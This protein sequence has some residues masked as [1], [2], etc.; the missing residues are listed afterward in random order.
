[1]D[2]INC[3]EIYEMWKIVHDGRSVWERKWE[4]GLVGEDTK[5]RDAG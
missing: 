1:M 2:V 3:D 4:G 5:I